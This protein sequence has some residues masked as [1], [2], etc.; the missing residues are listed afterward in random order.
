VLNVNNGLSVVGYLKAGGPISAHDGLSAI[1]PA[2]GGTFETPVAAV[3]GSNQY[4]GSVAYGVNGIGRTIGTRGESANG[5]GVEGQSSGAA[6]GVYGHNDGT[7]GGFGIAGRTYGTDAV[8]VYGDSQGK[9]GS[10]AGRFDGQVTIYGNLFVTGTVAKSGGM[11][12]IDHPLD[13]ENKILRHSFV[14]APEMLNVYSGTVKLDERGEAWVTLPPYFGALNRDYRYQLTN[15]GAFAPTYVAEEVKENKFKVAGGK[16]GMKVSWQVSGVRQD[17]YARDHRIVVEEE[18][19]PQ[20]R[21]RYF[22]AREGE[23]RMTTGSFA[24]PTDGAAMC[25][26]PQEAHTVAS[27]RN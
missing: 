9:S 14:E 22:Y 3:Y 23:P 17:L 20:D 8:A 6:S 15:V 11:F 4:T 21:G 1:I 10:L 7:N 19:A 27:K 16:P 25:V 13:R 5:N 2:G 18:K 12:M 26:A 24:S